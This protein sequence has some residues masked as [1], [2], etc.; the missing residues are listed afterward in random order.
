MKFEIVTQRTEV[1]CLLDAKN[2]TIKTH[3]IEVIQN[4]QESLYL[5]NITTDDECLV[6]MGV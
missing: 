6:A 5:Q 2:T 4:T 3:Q 1:S